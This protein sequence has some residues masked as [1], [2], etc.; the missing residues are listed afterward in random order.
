MKVQQPPASP[1]VWREVA[2]EDGSVQGLLP[3]TQ[4]G[5][6]VT[7]STVQSM[8]PKPSAMHS[9]RLHWVIKAPEQ[10]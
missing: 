2:T 10:E 4:L 1:Q 9:R 5:L 7:L 6:A 3:E 8:L